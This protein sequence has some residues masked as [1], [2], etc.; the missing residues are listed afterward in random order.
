MSQTQVYDV[1]CVVIQGLHRSKGPLILNYC[2]VRIEV[3]EN[4]AATNEVAKWTL[5]IALGLQ[6]S[7]NV[8]CNLKKVCTVVIVLSGKKELTLDS[9]LSSMLINTV[10]CLK[11]PVLWVRSSISVLI[12][13]T[14]TVMCTGQ[15]DQSNVIAKI[16]YKI[17]WALNCI[18]WPSFGQLC[19][20]L[21]SSGELHVT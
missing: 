4:N 8:Q 21:L 7:Q 20:W 14:T 9:A 12:K 11:F 17:V 5:R 3:Y 2:S 13:V 1:D 6:P 18:K 10:N 15:T 19:W 16:N